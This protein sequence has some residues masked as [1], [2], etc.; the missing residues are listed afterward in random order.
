MEYKGKYDGEHSVINLSMLRDI[1][2]V[3]INFDTL[4]DL[5]GRSNVTDVT[6]AVAGFTE[7]VIEGML[8]GIYTKVVNSD[9]TRQV[10][11][12]S[13]FEGDGY[14]DIY[15]HQGDGFDIKTSYFLRKNVPA[16]TW[17]INFYEI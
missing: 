14:K 17:T 4:T 13:A 1:L 5:D 12:Y 11:N 15:L 16:G 8:D 10:W 9:D 6:M 7:E 2:R 3:K